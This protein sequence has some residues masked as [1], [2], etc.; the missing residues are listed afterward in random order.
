[1]MIRK[2]KRAKEEISKNKLLNACVNG[3]GDLFNEVKRM[4]KHKPKVASSMDG[5]TEDIPSHFLRYIQ[6]FTMRHKRKMN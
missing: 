1:M 3:D 2:C 4:R 6:A 5:N